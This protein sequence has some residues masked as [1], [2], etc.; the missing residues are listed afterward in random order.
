MSDWGKV[1][2]RVWFHMTV[3]KSTQHVSRALYWEFNV[4]DIIL[5]ATRQMGTEESLAVPVHSCALEYSGVSPKEGNK[6][7]HSAQCT[8]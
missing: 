7:V 5:L 8:E 1:V 4:S 6:I 3:S 2:L